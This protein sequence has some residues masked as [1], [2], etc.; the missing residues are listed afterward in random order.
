MFSKGYV[1]VVVVSV[2]SMLQMIGPP[3]VTQRAGLPQTP[4]SV[5]QS[6]T[7]EQIRAVERLIATVN[8]SVS[9]CAAESCT[10]RCEIACS[11]GRLALCRDELPRVFGRSGVESCKDRPSDGGADPT[12]VCVEHE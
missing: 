6:P 7:V 2:S 1:A 12:C 11:A 8:E 9:K 3:R 4:P 5:N 10:S